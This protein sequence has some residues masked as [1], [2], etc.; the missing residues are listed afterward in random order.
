MQI[1]FRKNKNK[2][3]NKN[4]EVRNVILSST[5]VKERELMV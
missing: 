3:K 5:A 1:K 2:N 4:A